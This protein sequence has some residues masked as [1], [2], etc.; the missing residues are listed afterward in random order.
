MGSFLVHTYYFIRSVLKFR[1]QFNN[2]ICW[3]AMWVGYISVGIKK[4]ICQNVL[5]VGNEY[6]KHSL[7][8]SYN[9]ILDPTNYS[10]L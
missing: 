7:Y 9:D 6:T 2:A 3:S 10:F 4:K 8:P 5:S 1:S